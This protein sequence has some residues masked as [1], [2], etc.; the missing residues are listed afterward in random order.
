VYG[1]YFPVIKDILLYADLS[2][3]ICLTKKSRQRSS[4]VVEDGASDFS[5]QEYQPRLGHWLDIFDVPADLQ[6]F[7]NSRPKIQK[8]SSCK[9][10]LKLAITISVKFVG[11]PKRH[12]YGEEHGE[13]V[14]KKD[15]QVG[16]VAVDF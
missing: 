16:V 7:L 3:N 2:R 15:R 14:V 10:L 1:S 13:V 11:T 5:P 8:H 6:Q 12:E 4:S 9:V